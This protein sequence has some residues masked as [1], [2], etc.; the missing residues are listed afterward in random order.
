MVDTVPKGV[1]LTDVIEPLPVKPQGAQIVVLDDGTFA[2]RGDVRVRI[3]L[4][5]CRALVSCLS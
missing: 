4:D 3:S 1:Q 2:L 5:A